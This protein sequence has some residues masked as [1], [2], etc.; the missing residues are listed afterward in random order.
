[1]TDR[2]TLHTSLQKLEHRQSNEVRKAIIKK[3][4][5]AEYLLHIMTFDNDKSFVDHMTAAD[6]LNI[7]TYF[8]RS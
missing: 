3:L 6:A 7:N 8:P 4:K 1:M 5:K 2:A